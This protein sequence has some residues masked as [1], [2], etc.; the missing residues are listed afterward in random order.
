MDPRA[1]LDQFSAA[2]PMILSGL[3][4]RSVTPITATLCDNRLAICVSLFRP[5]SI[6]LRSPERVRLNLRFNLVGKIILYEQVHF[7]YSAAVSE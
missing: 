6:R 7:D 1:Y 3:P 2:R 4:R 5:A